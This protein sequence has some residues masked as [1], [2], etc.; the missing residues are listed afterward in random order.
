[1]RSSLFQQRVDVLL[2]RSITIS[3]VSHG[4]AN[5]VKALLSDLE[6]INTNLIREV[7]VT[8]NI[9][10]IHDLFVTNAK[11]HV[12]KNNSPKGFAANHNAAFQQATGDY[13][14][15]LNP[16]IRLK[17]NP[18]VTLLEEMRALKLAMI[19]PAIID[20]NGQYDDSVRKFP[21]IRSLLKR[22]ILGKHDHYLFSKTDK[23]LYPDW[24]GGMFML[25]DRHA[26]QAVN[27]FDE[28]YFLYYEDVDICVRLW[29]KGLPI[30]VSPQVSVIHQ[31]QR[32]SHRRL[33]YLR[34]H[35]NSMIRFFAKYRGRFPTIS[36]R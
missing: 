12:I 34:W 2:D 6:K 10:E 29:D 4:Q 16:D 23:V 21:T 36:N 31:A 32:Q 22:L 24:V 9:P 1:M 8:Y 15:V 30:A 35:L 5:L 25:F 17:D 19:A 18:F 20:E 7:I 28:Q 14:C 33:K 27:G 11:L 13:F 26:Y 3:V